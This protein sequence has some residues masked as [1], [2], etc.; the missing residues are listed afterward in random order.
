MVTQYAC[1]ALCR[2]AVLPGRRC[3]TID[4]SP[5][6]QDDEKGSHTG[7]LGVCL[8]WHVVQ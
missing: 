1:K 2:L 3:A 8:F 4:A 5:R 6:S 7:S